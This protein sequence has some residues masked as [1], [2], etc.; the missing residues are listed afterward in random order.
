M[1]FEITEI[2]K[3]IV[4]ELLNEVLDANA[5]AASVATS[6]SAISVPQAHMAPVASERPKPSKVIF[7]TILIFNYLILIF[8]TSMGTQTQQTADHGPT[9][10]KQQVKILLNFLHPFTFRLMM[11]NT[12]QSHQI[13]CQQT[14]LGV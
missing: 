14:F 4:S 3:K 1:I 9:A 12:G 11:P 10:K 13:Q 8:Q 5:A 2:F 6:A 7:I